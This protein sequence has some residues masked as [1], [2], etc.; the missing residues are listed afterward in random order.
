MITSSFNKSEHNYDI[1][2][3]QIFEDH[4]YTCSIKLTD[5]I[6]YSVRIICEYV[7]FRTIENDNDVITQREIVILVEKSKLVEE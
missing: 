7:S 1:V 4:Q 6:S 2:S 5:F 3:Y